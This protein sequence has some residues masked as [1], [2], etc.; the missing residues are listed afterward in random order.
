M[1]DLE[2]YDTA[3]TTTM[4]ELECG[5]AFLRLPAELRDTIYESVVKADTAFL[6]EHQ[7]EA[8]RLYSS[9]PLVSINKQIR[10]EYL[11]VLVRSA[12]CVTVILTDDNF[13]DV[14]RILWTLP[15][16]NLPSPSEWPPKSHQF[17]DF[18][19]HHPISAYAKYYDFEVWLYSRRLGASYLIDVGSSY[20]AKESHHQDSRG[21]HL[22]L[23]PNER[24][25]RQ[26]VGRFYVSVSLGLGDT[27]RS[28]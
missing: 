14:I 25:H 21:K 17:L 18:A 5:S 13:D 28:V 19:I 11:A 27:G 12:R 4:A 24:I 9:S 6:A 7:V 15:C 16:F 2:L 1:D 23:R 8:G 20:Q 26:A 22:I 10:E 3:D